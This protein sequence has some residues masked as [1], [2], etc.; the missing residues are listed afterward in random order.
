LIADTRAAQLRVVRGAQ[1]RELVVPAGESAT[2][3]PAPSTAAPAAP[4]VARV[5]GHGVDG[6][7]KSLSDGA[8]PVAASPNRLSSFDNSVL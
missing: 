6:E 2:P 5:L 1:A 4:R 3:G 7:K 8:R